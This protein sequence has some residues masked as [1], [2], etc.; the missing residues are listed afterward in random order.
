M[1]QLLLNRGVR[2]ILAAL[3]VLAAFRQLFQASR[4][5]HE[6]WQIGDWLI[7]YG[8][9]FV[10]RGLAGSLFRELSDWSG[11]AANHLVIGFSLM[12]FLSLVALLLRWGSKVFS[13]ALLL[14]CVVLG[15]PA[16]QDGMVRKDCLLLLLWVGCLWAQ[17]RIK[18][19]MFRF[20]AVNLLACTGVL[21]HE[22]FAFFALPGLVL[23]DRGGPLDWR[24]V[25]GRAFSI[26]PA[27]GC[28]AL[29]IIHH[30][31]PETAREIHESW[32]PLWREIEGPRVDLTEPAAAIAALGWSAGEGIGLTKG[33]WGAGL[34]QPLCWAMVFGVSTLLV[35]AFTRSE[36]GPQGRADLLGLLLF[37][38]I[39]ISP[40]FVV[41]IDYG[42]W[43]FLWVVSSMVLL[44]RERELPACVGARVHACLEWSPIRGVLDRL[45]G[46]EWVFLLFG[47]PVLWSLRNFLTAGPL[48]HHVWH[49]V[50]SF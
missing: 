2:V 36:P 17:D 44:L 1:K 23:L 27:L 15:F 48:P 22:A 50:N 49:W 30:G 46:H 25:A 20:L 12:A 8:N 40:L 32:L 34:Y 5:G 24:A 16:Y 13:P 4:W 3:L 6:S 14:S 21:M 47:V 37:Q 38:L 11:I 31:S 42:R 39:F 9:G 18:P 29:V 19:P 45:S 26:L 35:L 33:I 7:H 41:G 10:R 28:L 43:L